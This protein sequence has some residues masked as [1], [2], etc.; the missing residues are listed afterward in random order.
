VPKYFTLSESERLLPEVER[1][2]RD[3]LLH[4]AEY[5]EAAQALDAITQRVRFSGGTRVNREE[6][7]ALRAKRETSAAA[8]K[9]AIERIE[10]VGALV[11]DLDIGLIDF[12]TLYQDREVCLC[13]KLG[14]DRIRFWHGLEEGFRGRKPIDEEFLKSHH[15]GEGS[16]SL[17]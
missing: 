15:A 16:D 9:D 17:N 5:Q 4:K 3:A 11:K 10:Q 14:E 6:H 2:L 8:L 13:W 7:L 12:L 1:A